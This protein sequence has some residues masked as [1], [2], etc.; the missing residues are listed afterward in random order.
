[1]LSEGDRHRGVQ[2][3][4]AWLRKYTPPAPE[5]QQAPDADEL[6]GKLLE[7]KR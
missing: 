2:A 3:A 1:M 6:L 4:L 5:K 7:L